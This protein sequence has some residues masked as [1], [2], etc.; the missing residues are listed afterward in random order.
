VPPENDEA[1]KRLRHT[2]PA[3]P[4]RSAGLHQRT[5]LASGTAPALLRLLNVY[6]TGAAQSITVGVVGFPNQRRQ[7]RS[8]QHAQTGQWQS[9]S[10]CFPGLNFFCPSIFD[11]ACII[12]VKVCAICGAPGTHEGVAVCSTTTCRSSTRR[13]RQPNLH[14]WLCILSL[15]LGLF[16]IIISGLSPVEEI[17]ALTQTERLKKIYDLPTFSSTLEV[18]TMFTLSTGRLLKVCLSPSLLQNQNNHSF[19]VGWHP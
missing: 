15:H 17:L 10:S 13:R 19:P 1:L 3:L 6:R 8:N 18:L 2:T 9:A 11:G 12:V 14:R 5:N 16:A 4:F 7:R